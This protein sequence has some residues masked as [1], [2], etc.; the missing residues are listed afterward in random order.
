MISDILFV[1][2]VITGK[3]ELKREPLDLVSLVTHAI[4]IVRPSAEAKSI[5]LSAEISSKAAV[6]VEG[7]NE[8]LLQVL[9]NLLTNAIKFTPERGRISVT[10]TAE[11][12]QAVVEVRDNG[13]GIDP[14]FQPFLFEKFRQADS[15]YTRSFGG[16]GLGLAI[17]RHLVELHG[18]SV[19]G[20]SDGI[21]RGST[22]RVQLPLA[23][24]ESRVGLAEKGSEIAG[25]G[26]E[27]KLHKIRVLLVEDDADSR[28]MLATVLSHFGIETRSVES[29]SQAIPELRAYR[30]DLLISDVGLPGEDG[31]DLI[32]KVRELPKSEG[33]DVPA[34]ALTGYVSLQDRA[35]ALA[36]GYQA[37]LPKPVDTDDLVERISLLVHPRTRTTMNRES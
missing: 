19:S 35:L 7:D 2:R 17:V 28:E 13:Q 9:L 14:K 30:P 18:G 1:S 6:F 24:A 32:R 5:E 33:G 25:N 27:S 36:A 11:A 15:T 31:Y 3:L 26:A 29:A 16:L 37:H 10:Q 21:G 23:F 8:R 12:G 34:I 22:F 4:D 20:R